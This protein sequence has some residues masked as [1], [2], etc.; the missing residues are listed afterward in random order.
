MGVD[1]PERRGFTGEIGEHAHERRVFYNVSEIA[2]VKRVPVVH[3]VIV[4][5]APAP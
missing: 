2:G 3:D 4:R 1:D 5:V